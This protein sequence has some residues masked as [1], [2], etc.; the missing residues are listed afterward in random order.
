MHV[1]PSL[2]NNST[3]EPPSLGP[4][5]TQSIR[6]GGYATGRGPE[7]K[8]T[9]V[10][11]TLTLGSAADTF[12]TPGPTT[13]LNGLIP[14]STATGRIG[15]KVVM[16]SLYIR[17]SAQLAPTS[18]QG[19]PVRIIV[20]YDKQANGAAAGVTDVLLANAFNSPNNLSNRDRFVVLS[21]ELT[22]PISVQNN[23]A[24]SG[25]IY[26][27]INLEVMFNA[28]TAGT[29]ADITSGSVYIMAAQSSTIATAAPTV[30]FRSRIRYTD[31]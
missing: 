12:T 4:I 24:V 14:D 19:A 21:D 18:I 13:L 29:I 6:V 22:E 25:V 17:W 30:S 26:K 8:F 23:F 10:S 16:K 2:P 31:Q 7:K 5:A 28:G 11:A 20:F 27:K 3:S 15:R 9:D 1:Q